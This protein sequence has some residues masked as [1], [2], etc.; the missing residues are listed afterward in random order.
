LTPPGSARIVR[1]NLL[2]PGKLRSD[3]MWCARL[4]H[5]R[6]FGRSSNACEPREAPMITLE[7]CIDFSGLTKEE[8]LAIA[9]HEH[10]P[11]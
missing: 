11:R 5:Q 9:E 8:V 6:N 1:G 10:L 3:L 7:D 2:I 4:E